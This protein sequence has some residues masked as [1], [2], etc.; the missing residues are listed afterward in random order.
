[1]RLWPLMMQS[2]SLLPLAR[3]RIEMSQLGLVDLDLFSNN[4]GCRVFPMKGWPQPP[5]LVLLDTGGIVSDR[6][7][8]LSTATIPALRSGSANLEDEAIAEFGVTES[9]Y[10]AGYI[11]ADGRFLDLSYGR[12][13]REEDHRTV[14]RWIDGFDSPTDAMNEWM[15]RTGALRFSMYGGRPGRSRGHGGEPL[16]FTFD[17]EAPVT[18]AQRRTIASLIRMEPEW[19]AVSAPGS[20]GQETIDFPRIWDVLSGLG[21]P[22]SG[23]ANTASCPGQDALEREFAR[24]LGRDESGGHCELVPDRELHKVARKHGWRTPSGIVGFHTPKDEIY[25][26]NKNPWSVSHELAHRYGLVD[27]H[28]ARWLC[29]ALTE[30]VAEEASRNTGEP[31]QATYGYERSIVLQHV[32]PATG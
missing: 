5:S 30:F 3:L 12:G 22:K 24:L 14:A 28:M 13:E 25:V 32:A 29:E 21:V 8:P 23:M 9:P 18:N 7:L 20:Y 10:G 6:G 27:D 15:R 4:V 19:V 31:H 16:G 26:S 17:A 1:M 11:L 2:P